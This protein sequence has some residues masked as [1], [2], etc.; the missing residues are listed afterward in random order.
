M[1]RV[2]HI[3]SGELNGGGA[4]KSAL[5]LHNELINQGIES[6]ILT[7]GKWADEK[8][9]FKIRINRI[10]SCLIFFDNIFKKLNAIIKIQINKSYYFSNGKSRYKLK[11]NELISKADIIHL[12]WINGV[13]SINEIGEINKPMIWS[14]RDMW[15][16]TGGCHITLG[17][18]KYIN[19]C[20]F[21]PAIN[22]NNLMDKSRSNFE[23]KRN[24]FKKITPISI[25]KYM[26][27]VL[28]NSNIF[29]KPSY[30]VGN[31]IDCKKYEYKAK[32]TLTSKRIILI[33]ALN[34]DEDWKG[35]NYFIES[36]VH[37][38]YYNFEIWVV[39]K[40]DKSKFK[41]I[42]AIKFLGL[43]TNESV[44]ID[45][46]SKADVFV[47]PSRFE[48]F[49][50]ALAEA[51]AVGT[52][53]VCFDTSGQRDLIKHLCTGYKAEP[54]DSIDLAKGIDW[55]LSLTL[56]EYNEIA[57]AGSEYIRERYNIS[58]ISKEY[59]KIYEKIKI[60]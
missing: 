48:T 59:M 58:K 44:L 28:I 32:V 18:N 11:N 35:L 25:S 14:I 6:Y 13:V 27:E 3:V 53:S 36:I 60:P 20:G 22:S 50:K 42:D 39:G 7:N 38:D 51:L 29:E 23:L 1:L 10:G 26:D 43:I 55:V 34:W 40:V 45:I 37:I 33:S 8:R 5:N 41:N 16:V 30:Y 49:G 2:V 15:P 57:L 21:C 17:C 56:Y 31:A 54:Y 19:G 24:S 46:Y 9:I 4:T 52:L 47:M 12:H